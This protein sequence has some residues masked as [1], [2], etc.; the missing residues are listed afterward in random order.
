[1]SGIQAQSPVQGETKS[2]ENELNV[3]KMSGRFYGTEGKWT[4]KF[5][6][7]FVKSFTGNSLDFKIA[8]ACKVSGGSSLGPVDS[9][10]FYPYVMRNVHIGQIEEALKS[11][12]D[13]S[14]I[15]NGISQSSFVVDD[16]SGLSEF[17]VTSAR[18]GLFGSRKITVKLTEVWQYSGSSGKNIITLTIDSD[19]SMAVKGLQNKD[20]SKTTGNIVLIPANEYR[21]DKLY[22][23]Q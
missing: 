2:I 5:D 10:G 19:G 14:F 18:H 6:T 1:M 17:Y 22:Q 7:A 12:K 13:V 15:V 16:F 9:D 4:Y 8:V 21:F 3:S 23:G 11:K 20:R